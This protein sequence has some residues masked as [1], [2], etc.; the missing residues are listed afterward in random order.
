MAEIK[1]SVDSCSYW[2]RGNVCEADEIMVR[3]NKPQDYD[4]EIGTMGEVEAE[5]SA[6]TMCETFK[7]R[8]GYGK[9]S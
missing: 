8:A 9:K 1:C 6:Q 5:T 2:G 4:M 3:N 7:P